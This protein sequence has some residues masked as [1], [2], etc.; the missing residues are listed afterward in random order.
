MWFDCIMFSMV[1]LHQEDYDAP[2]W[3]IALPDV[4]Q[5]AS[6]QFGHEMADKYFYHDPQWTNLNHGAFGGV[7]KPALEFSHVRH[8]VKFADA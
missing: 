2:E 3:P 5:A 4:S 1:C 7:L 6:V 8:T